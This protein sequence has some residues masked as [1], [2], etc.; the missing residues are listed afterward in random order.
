VKLHSEDLLPFANVSGRDK[1]P[2]A[3]CRGELDALQA[4]RHI[5]LQQPLFQH[6]ERRRAGGLD[7]KTLMPFAVRARLLVIVLARPTAARG[8]KEGWQNPAKGGGQHTANHRSA[9]GHRRR[10]PALLGCL[11]VLLALL[12]APCS[13]AG[14][15]PLIPWVGF[16]WV[17]GVV[18]GCLSE[19]PHRSL[20]WPCDYHYKY[21]GAVYLRQD[22]S[23]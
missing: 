3:G 1:A 7:G 11:A 22:G 16:D 13:Q 9:G 23:L 12:A 6:G 10:P 21:E 4:P 5:A 8:Q 18:G 17:F 2:A 19:Q 14:L 15:H 20:L